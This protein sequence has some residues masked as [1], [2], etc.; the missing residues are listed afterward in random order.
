MVTIGFDELQK[1]KKCSSMLAFSTN[2]HAW[3]QLALDHG[4]ELK[5]IIKEWQVAVVPSAV[6]VGVVVAV[7]APPVHVDPYLPFACPDC[8]ALFSSVPG[9]GRH[10]VHSHSYV[11]PIR[12]RVAGSQCL[13]CNVDFCSRPRLIQHLS[14]D[15]KSCKALFL[16]SEPVVLTSEE[17]QMLDDQDREATRASRK[18]GRSIRFA[19]RPAVRVIA[20]GV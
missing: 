1:Y 4:P 9:V 10:R 16:A 2:P 3:S 6:P 13:V 19:V 11:H 17:V 8:G 15:S 12:Q 18:L 20:G 14:H 7:D 5:A